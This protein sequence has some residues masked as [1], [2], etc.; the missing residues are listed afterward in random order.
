MGYWTPQKSTGEDPTIQKHVFYC[1]FLQQMMHSVR[2]H[3]IC[4]ILPSVVFCISGCFFRIRISFLGSMVGYEYIDRLAQKETKRSK[5]TFLRRSG[6]DGWFKYAM[7]RLH[8]SQ[9]FSEIIIDINSRGVS[10]LSWIKYQRIEPHPTFWN[11]LFHW[12]IL[13][14]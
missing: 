3:K 2:P 4:Y 10:S 6:T 13:C 14:H 1:H 7:Q 12:Q 11:S 5:E 9:A 8:S